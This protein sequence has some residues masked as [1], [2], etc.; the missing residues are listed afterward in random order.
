MKAKLYADPHAVLRGETAIEVHHDGKLLCVV[1]GS[2][3][4]GIRIVSK[5]IKAGSDF[6]V[7]HMQ[8]GPLGVVEIM[9]R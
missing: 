6:D 9:I 7:S 4:P 8:V 1:Y 2:D 3:G 5:Y